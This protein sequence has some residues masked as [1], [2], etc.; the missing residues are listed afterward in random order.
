VESVDGLVHLD[1]LVAR[2]KLL[3]HHAV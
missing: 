1:Q 3:G 2:G